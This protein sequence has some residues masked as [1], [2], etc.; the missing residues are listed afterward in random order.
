M[1]LKIDDEEIGEW[2]SVQFGDGT[3]IALADAGGAR[4]W[5]AAA[6]TEVQARRRI[7]LD[8]HELLLG[9]DRQPVPAGAG[10]WR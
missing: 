6:P 3:D 5:S 4:S 9:L 7:D 10:A 2:I 8:V 1:V